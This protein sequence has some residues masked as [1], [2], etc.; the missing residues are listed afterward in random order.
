[1]STAARVNAAHRAAMEAHRKA[2]KRAEREALANHSQSG[3]EIDP[4]AA[5]EL[6]EALE[7][8]GG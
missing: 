1:M 4:E 6:S 7:G 3:P 5:L 2:Q 8:S